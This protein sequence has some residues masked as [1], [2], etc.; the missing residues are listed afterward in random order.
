MMADDDFDKSSDFNKA[1]T[2]SIPSVEEAVES[3]LEHHRNKYASQVRQLEICIE[4]A[5]SRGENTV[6]VDI[7]VL[8]SPKD[9]L[10]N[11]IKDYLS[12]LGY[13]VD[14]TGPKNVWQGTRTPQ[15]GIRTPH[16]M[17]RRAPHGC[18]DTHNARQAGEIDWNY[19]R[20]ESTMFLRVDEESSIVNY[21]TGVIN[22]GPGNN[23]Q[24]PTPSTGT[25]QHKAPIRQVWVMNPPNNR[26]TRGRG[27]E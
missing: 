18:P 6:T 13:S 21:Q 4:A 12:W 2:P 10:V 19:I 17:G 5:I 14:W 22:W 1:G 23:I 25:P 3:Y 26:L 27:A 16:R 7:Q 15:Q 8:V 9:E 11:F 24:G 20:N